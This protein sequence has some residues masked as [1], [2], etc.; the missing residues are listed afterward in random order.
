MDVTE[1]EELQQR[2]SRRRL[3]RI[4]SLV[5]WG[6][7]VCFVLLAAIREPSL[8][9]IVVAGAFV[10]LCVLVNAQLFLI[11]WSG[12]RNWMRLL[13]RLSGSTYLSDLQN[14]PNRNYLLAEL[15]REM[16]QSRNTGRP[17][18]LVELSIDGAEGIRERRGA[19]FLLRS[20]R[21]LADLLKRVTRETDFVAHSEGS[22]FCV[23]LTDCRLDQALIYLQRVPTIIAVSDGRQMYDVPVAVRLYEYDRE[24]IYATDVLRSAE[25]AEPLGRK[26]EITERDW[27]EAA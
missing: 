17:F 6:A 19:D 11:Q 23:I 3:L 25:E 27:S 15:R 9:N 5:G 21:A 4:V 26:S 22:K 18:V 13:S 14:L 12:H 10:L 7:A 8:A 1:G 20:T 2:A 16:P 24:A